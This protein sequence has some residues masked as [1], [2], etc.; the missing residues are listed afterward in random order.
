M[1][2][3]LRA[4]KLTNSLLFI[5]KSNPSFSIAITCKTLLFLFP[6]HALSSSCCCSSYYCYS[7]LN[8]TSRKN[9]NQNQNQLLKSVR[10]ECKVGSF[11]NV[12]HALD[13]IDTMLHMRPLPSILDFIILLNAIAS[14]KHYSLVI[15]LI[16]QIESLGI[17]P[18]LYTLTI[19]INC[20]YHL[21][22]V[23]FGFFV[24]ATILKLG[25][26]PNHITLTTPVKGLGCLS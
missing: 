7:T 2:T 24:L 22:R 6:F 14:M 17:S 13:L 10:D 9:P 5:S 12:D 8:T 16:K 25:F 15:T 4:S 23:A 26:Q 11:R 20:F 18:D 1:G 3:L 21:N 19:L